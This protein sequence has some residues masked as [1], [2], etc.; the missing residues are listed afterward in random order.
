MGLDNLVLLYDNNAVTCD[1]PL[2]WIDSEDIN[3][4][5]KATGWN[6]IDVF[7]GDESVSDIVSAL[8]LARSCKCK[9]TFINVRTTI[10]YGTSSAGT[11]ESHH[12]K[13]DAV[14]SKRFEV[15]E[16]QPPHQPTEETRQYLAAAADRGTA[17]AKQ[18]VSDLE[19]YAEEYPEEAAA[20]KRRING[21]IDYE[22]L[23]ETMEV[24]HHLAATRESNGWVFGKL[25]RH[26][27]GIFAGGADVWGP[28][29]LGDCSDII[30]DR[31]NRQGH[32]LRYG[33]REHAMASISNGI[34]AYSRHAFLP[35]TATFFMFYLY[36]AAG[37]RMGALNR[38]QVVHIATHD[39]LNEGQNGPTHQPVELDSLYRAMPGL[40]YI[41]PCDAEEVIGAWILALGHRDSS[42]IISVAREGPRT[43]VPST[44]RHS[45]VRGGYA[46]H[47]AEDAQV[48]LVSAGS[49]VQFA[50]EAARLLAQRGVAARVVSMPCIEVFDRQPEDYREKVIS[51]SPH[52]VSIEPYVSYHWARYCTASIGVDTFGFSASGAANYDRYGLD[53]ESVTEKVLRHLDKVKVNSSLRAVKWEAL[54]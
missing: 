17:K 19:R 24:P 25:V 45:V 8:S 12:G 50:V 4:K 13:Y 2:D 26:I 36:A 1:G 15:Y 20:L 10:G 34:A 31:H 14:D 46:I 27:E 47:E 35:V 7:A 32:V 22:Q 49:E 9:P 48:T 44:D 53:G 21:D 6:V 5:M 28:N 37:V 54:R 52:V 29:K 40:L 42:T 16:G 43:R 11:A 3:L 51:A 23:L 41:R 39:S 18:W 38:L 33:I 30:F